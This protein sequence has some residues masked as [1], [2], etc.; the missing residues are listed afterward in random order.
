MR[1][2][3]LAAAAASLVVPA[4]ADETWLLP[5]PGFYC[6]SSGEDVLPISVGP[7][8]SMGIDGLDCSD[9]R[10]TR[11]RARSASCWANGGYRVDLDTDLLVLP[12][13]AMLH[14]SVIYRRWT[15]PLPCPR[16]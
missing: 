15:G 5:T 11:G 6:P 16:S 4:A 14:D 13:G 12:S 3:I 7:R 1:T 10:L 9:V 8:G 2:L